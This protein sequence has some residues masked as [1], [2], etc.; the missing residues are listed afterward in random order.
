MKTRYAFVAGVLA[1]A[2][3]SCEKQQ[4]APLQQKMTFCVTAEQTLDPSAVKAALD[5]DRKV[6]FAVGEK[7]SVF[8]GVANNPFEA[9]TAGTSVN[10]TGSAASA[11]TYNILSPYDAEATIAGN[12]ITA[13]VPKVQTAVLNGADPKALVAVART[14]DTGEIHLKNV[15][16]LLKVTVNTANA[17]REIQVAAGATRNVAI[18]GTI[19]ITTPAT[20]A[21]D[22]VY[23]LNATAEKVT[24]VSLVPPTGDDFLAVGTYYIG[25]LNKTYEGGLTVGYIQAD[26]T[27][28]ARTGASDAVMQR[29][30]VLNLGNLGDGYGAGY[31][32]VSSTGNAIFPAGPDVLLIWKKLA[33]PSVAAFH[34][35]DNTITRI[36]IK[37]NTL[38]GGAGVNSHTGPSPHPIFAILREGVLTLY[39]RASKAQLAG[40]AGAT[41]MFRSLKK[42]ETVDFSNVLI[43]NC[44]TLQR[45]FR[46]CGI[47]EVDL[48]SLD[49]KNVTNMS[50]MFFNCSNLKKV[51]LTGWKTTS[52]TS[53]AN[54]NGF[55]WMFLNATN[56]E[57]LRLG[58]DFSITT[59]G[60]TTRMFESASQAVSGRGEKCKLYCAESFWNGLVAV[61]DPGDSMDP[62]T[63]FNKARFDI[64]GN[65]W[66]VPEP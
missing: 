42:L 38:D 48:S 18:A 26:G 17:V 20:S 2:L 45:M 10:F 63:K 44:T 31:S 53:T 60:N 11:A 39:T 13:T 55:A 22:P 46:E 27:L 14:T 43:G 40:G 54:E 5:A 24:C 16:G 1:A 61:C 7:I 23:T 35:D 29:S 64:S 8:D 15:V 12:V 57:E 51:N 33:N 6:T 4:D 37:T 58:D 62:T 65:S 59:G 28:R 21:E 52:V 25:V 66:Y 56:L 9:T 50:E 41:N 19:D 34:T 30:H 47:Q 36:E 49:T 32:L 3:V